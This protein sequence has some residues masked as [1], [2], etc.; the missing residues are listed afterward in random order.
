MLEVVS[1][2]H[3]QFDNIVRELPAYIGALPKDAQK[4]SKQTMEKITGFLLH[5][6]NF[7]AEGT[8]RGF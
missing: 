8:L 1:D 5:L 6:Q 2:L 7:L 4:G 3:G